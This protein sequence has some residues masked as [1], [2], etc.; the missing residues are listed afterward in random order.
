MPPASASAASIRTAAPI[1]RR[2]R[3]GAPR[4]RENTRARLLAGVSEVMGL[5]PSG[6]NLKLS[7][8]RRALT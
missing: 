2:A 6:L 8:L 3:L 7:G 4:R 1:R 5:C